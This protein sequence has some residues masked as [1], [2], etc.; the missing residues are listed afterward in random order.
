M[1]NTMKPPSM[2]RLLARGPTPIA[3]MLQKLPSLKPLGGSRLRQ[4]TTVPID[5]VP[6]RLQL[7][8][9]LVALFE[10]SSGIRG[11]RQ[12][13]RRVSTLSGG[14]QCMPDANPPKA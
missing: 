1:P 7:T 9:D 5:L 11:W 13:K 8:S 12:S 2:S 3:K 4:L 14:E 6:L 10:P